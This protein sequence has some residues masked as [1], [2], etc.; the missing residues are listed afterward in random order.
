[1]PR[2]LNKCEFIGNLGNDPELKY[3][4]DNNTAIANFS[5][6]VT[7]REKV[8]GSWQD[9]TNWIRCVAF[10]STAE[11]VSKYL[12]K[13]SSVWVSTKVK[14]R[15]WEDSDGEKHYITEYTVNELIMLD[16][17]PGGSGSKPEPKV[18]D[19]DDIPF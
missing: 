6:G 4:G 16:K 18:P 14:N 15:S 10:G 17:A 9:V 5:V 13:G 7:T 11:T 12:K 1:M 19:D 3:I 8:K 2:G